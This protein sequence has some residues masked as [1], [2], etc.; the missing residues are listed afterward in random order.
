MRIN[1]GNIGSIAEKPNTRRIDS[2]KESAAN[3]N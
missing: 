1:T 3:E 2:P